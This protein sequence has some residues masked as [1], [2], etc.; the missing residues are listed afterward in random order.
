MTDPIH[1]IVATDL[2]ERGYAAVSRAVRLAGELGMP[3]T[4]VHVVDDELPVELASVILD[5]AGGIVKAQVRR[6]CAAL[7]AASDGLPAPA[8]EL[9]RGR[10][11]A[12][13][14]KRMEDAGAGLLVIG[15]HRHD[16]V[17]DVF[18]VTTAERVLRLV[19]KPVLVVGEPARRPY[20]E[21][22]VA[23]DFSPASEQA[24][25][26]AGAIAPAARR[27]LLHVT[28][29][30]FQGFMSQSVAAVQASEAEAELQAVA[31][32][33]GWD[34]E[35][36]VAEGAV[37]DAVLH[38]AERRVADL[39]AIGTSARSPSMNWFFGSV[40]QELIERAGC[41][42]LIARCHGPAATG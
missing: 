40:A 18:G 24:A 12:V 36:A 34:C 42:T 21:A 23:V 35:R 11:H 1:A 6:A 4:V 10:P 33:L 20:R 8:L 14:A 27:T 13:L 17:V 19:S 7:G 9:L 22:V 39:V 30:P 29:V 41:D 5:E 31:T 32:R 28:D 38:E 37:A 16:R 15:R 25:I 26:V 3:L 2:T